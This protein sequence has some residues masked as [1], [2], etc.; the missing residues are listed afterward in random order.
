MFSAVSELF[1]S[2]TGLFQGYFP[3]IQRCS[4]LV[5]FRHIF[6]SKIVKKT[7]I[8]TTFSFFS[9]HFLL[10]TLYFSL[11]TILQV[12]CDQE[13]WGKGG[14]AKSYFWLNFRRN[15][16][17]IAGTLQKNMF[18]VIPIPY[19][20]YTKHFRRFLNSFWSSSEQLWFRE[21]QRWTALV[22]LTHSETALKF[23]KSLKQ[24]CSALICSGTSTRVA[25]APYGRCWLGRS[26]FV[27]F[28][29]QK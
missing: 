10:K 6:W 18:F 4:A 2:V 23:M 19:R 5:K 9:V 12:T 26:R 15:D 8:N 25:L 16:F 29:S 3:L 11:F 13:A 22:F 17:F 14:C 24:C 27:I 28:K 20:T 21:N 7:L 1:F